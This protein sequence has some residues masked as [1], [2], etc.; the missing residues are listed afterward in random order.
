MKYQSEGQSDVGKKRAKNEDYFLINPDKGETGLV[1]V[2]DGVGGKKSG[3]VA[4]ETVAG[5]LQQQFLNHRHRFEM[6][7]LDRDQE[8]REG[9]LQL[10]SQMIETAN[11]ETYTFSRTEPR[12]EGMSTTAVVLVVANH[13]AFLGHV[14]DSRAYLVRAGEIYSLTEDHTLVNQLIKQRCIEPEKARDHPYSSVLL[15]SIGSHPH[16]EVDTAYIQV[17]HGDRFIVC[18]DG[19]HSYLSDSEILE[20]NS[21]SGS[22]K[23]LVESL[24]QEALNRGGNDNIT[25]VVVESSGST[26]TMHTLALQEEFRLLRGVF[27][28]EC[29]SDQEIMRV[30]RIMYKVLRRAGEVI[31][32]EGEQ[33]QEL[34]IVAEGSVDVTL[35]D[36]HLATIEPGGHFGELALIDNEVRSATVTA[37]TNVTLLTIKQKDFAAFVEEDHRLANKL[38]WSF[39]RVMAG[40]IRETSKEFVSFSDLTCADD[41]VTVVDTG[42]R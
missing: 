2:A 39:L 19:L 11:G 33:G 23:E 25:V 38:F 6:Y 7:T 28:F 30:I 15:R 20:F 13:G 10:V 14:G 37:R 34:Y 27:L 21:R 1:V 5:Q 3:E 22:T 29:L 9:L 17:E 35:R 41:E 4:S 24:I 12:Y 36:A 16:V 8:L 32:C 42:K 26:E 40:H 18:S 31:I